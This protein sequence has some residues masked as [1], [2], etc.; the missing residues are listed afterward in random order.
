[1]KMKRGFCKFR[2]SGTFRE[3][4]KLLLFRQFVNVSRVHFN[5]DLLI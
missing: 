1:M 3:L 5:I 4:A 2:V